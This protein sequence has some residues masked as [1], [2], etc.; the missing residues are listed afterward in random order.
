[1]TSVKVQSFVAL[2]LQ[3]GAVLLQCVVNLIL[4]VCVRPRYRLAEQT[5]G[6]A[7]SVFRD[8]MFIEGSQAVGDTEIEP[9]YAADM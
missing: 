5:S 7:V 3:Y 8:T 1:M 6:V 2:V 4:D 9:G